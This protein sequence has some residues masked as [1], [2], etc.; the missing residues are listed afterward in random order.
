MLRLFYC[1]LL[2]ALC[3][4]AAGPSFRSDVFPILR[5]NCLACHSAQTKM[6]GLVMEDYAG[7]VHGGKRGPALVKGDAAGSLLVQMLTGE[8]QPAMPL[9]GK[10]PPQNLATI[11]AW[12]DAGAEGEEVSSAAPAI[13]NMKPKVEAESPIAAV[14]FSPDGRMLAIGE[15]HAVTLIDAEAGVTYHVLD[16]HAEMVRA[17]AFSPDGT[18]L[19]AAGGRPLEGGE[20]KIWDWAEGKLLQTIDGHGDAIYGVDFSPDGKRLATASYDKLV[21]LWDVDSGAEIATL[22]DHVDAVFAVD[23]GPKPGQLA[24]GGADRS[25]KLWDLQTNRPSATLSDAEAGVTA[26]E[27]SPDGK[28]LAAAGKDKTLRVWD[29]TGET[30]LSIK[31]MTGHEAEVLRIA[32]SPDG[33]TL[34][35]ASADGTVKVWD[36]ETLTEKKVLGDQ[37]DWAMALAYSPRGDVLAVGRYD[38][39]LTLYEVKRGFAV[40]RLR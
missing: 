26:V 14:A 37:P 33:R 3:L 13:P 2:A 23:F 7:L 19:A 28:R 34:T 6:G 36:A 17:V 8:V 29:L 35:S 25:I 39:S 22:K 24:S 30:P 38:G 5:D 11:K 15:L 12:I 32:Y 1:G 31:N 18:L 27:F 21:K 4:N 20:V 9:N 16:G 40:R 10:L